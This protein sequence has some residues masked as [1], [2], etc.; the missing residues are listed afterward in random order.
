[1]MKKMRLIRQLGMTDCG[2]ACLTMLFNYYHY[3]SDITKISLGANVG[4]D[5]VSLEDMKLICEQHFFKFKAYNYAN[6]EQN[7]IQ[8]LPVIMCSKENHYVVIE[9]RTKHGFH[10]LDPAKG[11]KIRSFSEIVNHFLNII[12]VIRPS[13]DRKQQPLPKSTKMRFKIDWFKMVVSILLTVAAQLIVLI[14]PGIIQ[15]II[16]V[17]SKDSTELN[18][19]SVLGAVLL[20][21]VAYF[22]VT[23]LRK[24]LILLIQNVLYKDVILQML[25]KVFKID[26]RFFEGHTSGDIVNRFNNVSMINE[27]LSSVM[28]TVSI[29]VITAIVCGIA[30]FKYS[31]S[32]SLVVCIVTV[33]QLLIIMLLNG[34]VQKKTSAY[35]AKQGLLQGELFNMVNNIIQIRNMGI[36][37]I[38]FDNLDQ[39]YS[40]TVLLHKKRTQTSDLMESAISSI[41]IVTSLLLYAVG[42]GLVASGDLSLGQLVG[43]IALSAFFINP[44]RALSTML[45]QLST[46]KEVFIRVKELLNYSDITPSGTVKVNDFEVMEFADVSFSYSRRDL[47]NLKN[48]NLKVVSGQKIAIVGSSGSGKTTI[49]K[50]I[51]NVLHKY[52]GIISINKHN[53]LEID[54]E[55]FYQKVAVVTQTPLVINGTIRSNI[56]FTGNLTNEQIYD[57]L[58]KAEMEDDVK[59]FPLQLETIMG[60]NGQNLSGG[61]KQRV[62]IARALA[63]KP[64]VIIFDEATSNL[65]PITERKIFANLNDESVTLIMITHR[66]NVLQKVDH[67]YVLDRGEVAEHGTHDELMKRKSFYYKSF[68]GVINDEVNEGVL[69]R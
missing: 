24:R 38:M 29:D 51:M 32:L 40:E 5:G 37:K 34:R 27:F 33:A 47:Y 16:D 56:D 31:I 54:K 14:I 64:S 17:L 57:A 2:T 9:K 60:E 53:I 45:P 36:E 43:F 7:L 68:N 59:G 49:T 4:R 26:T 66:L 12:V 20:I 65:D 1:M 61:Q 6:N 11:K 10:V 3:R 42:G 44:I 46:L 62:A 13:E 28:V 41:N 35:M 39:G 23:W 52:E 55:H 15:K 21:A 67:I 58:K 48:I 25:K 50:L 63:S 19:Y 22:G 18:V 69:M 8:H 30:M